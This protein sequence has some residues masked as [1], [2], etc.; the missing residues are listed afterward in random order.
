MRVP[1]LAPRPQ[2]LEAAGLDRPWRHGAQGGAAGVGPAPLVQGGRPRRPVALAV[3]PNDPLGP[4]GEPR[5]AP[6]DHGAVERRGNL[7]LGALAHAPRPRQGAPLRADVDPQRHPATASATASPPPH[8]RLSGAR[9]PE[10]LG[11][12]SAIPLLHEAGAV[13]PAGTALDT[14]LGRAALGDLRRDGGP[15]RAL[16][17]HEAAAERGQRGHVSGA[18]PG[19]WRRLGWRAGITDGTI[20]AQGVTHR[21]RPLRWLAALP[22]VDDAPTF[23]HCLF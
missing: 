4:R 18:V 22:D 8:A 2:G 15:R 10:A 13:E 11:R 20:T 14:A 12:R 17:T 21:R 23:L 1:G 6:L 5:A 3:T 7:A 16:P 19:G 9:R